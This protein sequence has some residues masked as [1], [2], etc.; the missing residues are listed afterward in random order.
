MA[1]SLTMGAIRD[2]AFLDGIDLTASLT[3]RAA[4]LVAGARA[5]QAPGNAARSG[6][7]PS[8]P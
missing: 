3:E 1:S 6:T 5:Y 7:S 2:W 8:E 4:V